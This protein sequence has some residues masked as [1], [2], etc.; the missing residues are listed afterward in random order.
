MVTFERSKKVFKNEQV[1]QEEYTPDELIEREEE[2]E[3]Y[4]EALQPVANAA[5]PRN[6]FV[7][8]DTG[9]GKTVATRMI[10]NE[11]SKDMEQF[12]DVDVEVVWANCKELTSYQT[13]VKLVNSFRERSQKI[14]MSGHSNAAVYDMLWEEIDALDATHLYIV[15]DEVDSLGTDDDLLYKLPRARSNQDINN[16]YLGLIGISNNFKFRDNL[17]ARVKSTL[18]E[19]EIRFGPYDA[20]E[21]Q[22]I[23]EQRAEKAFVEGMLISGVI[24]LVAASAAQNT[25]SARRALDILYNAGSL[26]RKKDAD[27]VTEDHVRE[28]ISLVEKGVIE[29]ELRDLPT[30]SHLVLYAVALLAE[31]G[32]LPARRKRIYEVYETI[33]T[34]LDTTVK[35]KRTVLNRLSQLSLKGFLHVDEVN[36]G[37]SGGKHYQYEL[38]IKQDLLLNILSENNRL[39]ELMVDQNLDQFS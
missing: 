39:E 24:P 21:L 6:I 16:T 5:S 26:A 18:C 9:V 13:A 38:D 8:G 33:A 30:Q 25:G 3:D 35:A 11:L 1:L 17:S 29:D 22:T 2:R 37:R 31:Q 27:A 10:L 34:R 19:H 15:L 32:E 12:D 36:K 14:S 7:Y 4:I 28:A 23:L 20:G